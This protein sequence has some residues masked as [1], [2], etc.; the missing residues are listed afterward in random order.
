LSIESTTLKPKTGSERQWE[1][2]ERR[3][4]EGW[5]QKPVWLSPEVQRVLESI[6]D[7]TTIEQF[8]ND[9]VLSYDPDST[10]T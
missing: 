5:K 10:S 6:P 7:D 1:Y 3:K 8:I 4:A 9:A 2:R